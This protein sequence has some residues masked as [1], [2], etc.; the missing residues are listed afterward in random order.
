VF[1]FDQD[2]NRVFKLQGYTDDGELDHFDLDDAKIEGDYSFFYPSCTAQPGLLGME[3]DSMCR[4][5]CTDSGHCTIGP[6]CTVTISAS[7]VS[8]KQCQNPSCDLSNFDEV[9]PASTKIFR[10]SESDG[11]HGDFEMLTHADPED[12]TYSEQ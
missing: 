9:Y 2:S 4:E 3:I 12:V 6:P 8:D 1:H 11:I 10:V 7:T 5:S